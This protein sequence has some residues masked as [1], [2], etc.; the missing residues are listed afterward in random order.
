VSPSERFELALRCLCSAE[1]A[2]TPENK[3]ILLAIAERWMQPP[4]FA[5]DDFTGFEFFLSA[6][7]K[8]NAQVVSI[9]SEACAE[10]TTGESTGRGISEI[11]KRLFEHY[12]LADDKLAND[13]P[14]PAS[15][16]SKG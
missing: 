5:A 13:V 6:S 10:S 8:S 16:D 9:A 1:T 3:E 11:Q 12:K 2:L 14:G 15:Q 4:A 7:E